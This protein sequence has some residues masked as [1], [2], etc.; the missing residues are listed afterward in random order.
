MKRIP[1]YA[2]IPLGVVHVQGIE[3]SRLLE[4]K[5]QEEPMPWL[6]P[7][8]GLLQKLIRRN[9]GAV[10]AE[11][12][13]TARLTSTLTALTAVDVVVSVVMLNEGEDRS[14]EME[15]VI[16]MLFMAAPVEMTEQLA[17]RVSEQIEV[18][19]QLSGKGVIEV[20]FSQSLSC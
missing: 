4:G 17:L 10:A 19:G 6:K 14:V 2:P 7:R 20:I 5:R 1:R 12:G 9:V 16:Q 3:E 11:E 15:Q 8:H 13:I 18:I